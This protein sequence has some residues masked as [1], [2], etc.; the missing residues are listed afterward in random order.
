MVVYGFELFVEVKENGCDIYFEVSVVGGI[1]ILCMLEEGFL[2]DWIIKMMGIVNG[3]MNFILIKMIKEKSF[4]EEVFKEVQDF[5]FVE[6]DLILDV[7]GFDVV[8]KMV[9]LVCFGFL[10][11]VDLEDVKVKGIF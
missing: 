10:M 7:E 8:R 6:V 4:Y 5:G 1:L 11:N 2:L 9:I 3:I